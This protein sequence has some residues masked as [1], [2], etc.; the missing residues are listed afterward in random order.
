MQGLI[1]SE[2]QDYRW[3]V[4]VLFNI[5]DCFV[6][7]FQASVVYVES[8]TSVPAV[9]QPRKF[10]DLKEET[11]NTAAELMSSSFPV[12]NRYP[13][14]TRQ[15]GLP[16]QPRLTVNLDSTLHAG[17]TGHSDDA[18]TEA[19]SELTTTTA[20]PQVC[21]VNEKL[22]PLLIFNW[23]GSNTTALTMSA[24]VKLCRMSWIFL[25]TTMLFLRSI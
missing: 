14:S 8:L 4:F 21:T 22:L 9:I 25:T 16:V 2:L 12:S 11:G 19:H 24:I 13:G 20:E 15:T 23:R 3:N 5:F 10:H 6:V 7:D 1:K 17:S 18:T